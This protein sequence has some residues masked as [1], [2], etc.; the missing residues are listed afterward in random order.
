MDR[1]L[2]IAHLGASMSLAGGVGAIY[3]MTAG[4]V[5]GVFLSSVTGGAAIVPAAAIGAGI[6]AGAGALVGAASA[7]ATVP[8]TQLAVRS[9]KSYD[10]DPL[11]LVSS[12]ESAL[13]SKILSTEH[14]AAL[15]WYA[16]ED[17]SHTKDLGFESVAH[18]GRWVE[19]A[20]A[21]SESFGSS[22][23]KFGEFIRKRAFESHLASVT[24]MLPPGAGLMG[25]AMIWGSLQYLDHAYGID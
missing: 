18:L 12:V 4:G 5:G 2:R 3:G 11:D 1:A 6:G 16:C 10:A 13:R 17:F 24:S 15:T 22:D 7:F 19:G 23:G 20:L 14:H 8:A 25:S 21:F 9:S